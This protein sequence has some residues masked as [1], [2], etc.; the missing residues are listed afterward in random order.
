MFV[1]VDQHDGV[2]VISL[3]GNLDAV[4]SPRLDDCLKEQLSQ[5]HERLVLDFGKVGYISSAGL[6]VILSTLKDARQKGGNVCLAAVQQGVYRVLEMS[7]LTSILT[8]CGDADEAVKNLQ[9]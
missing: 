4:T 8:L 9:K 5:G 1:S 3:D 7:G 2:A 6:R